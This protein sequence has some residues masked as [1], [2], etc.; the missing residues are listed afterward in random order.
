MARKQTKG[1]TTNL[2]KLVAWDI[3]QYI[4]L[5]NQ[6]GCLVCLTEAEKYV[7]SCALR[8]VPW[9]T[10]WTSDL[11]TQAPDIQ[12][13]G[14]VLYWKMYEDNCID[15]CQEILDCIETNEDIQRAIGQYSLTSAVTSTTQTNDGI[16]SSNVIGS[17]V[18][19]NNDQIFGMTIQLV[20]LMNTISLTLLDRFVASLNSAGNLGYLI[21]A[22]PVIGE[23]PLDDI[24]AFVQTVAVQIN[25]EY[26][27]SS[28]VQLLED[29][30]CKLFC[31]AKE[32]CS[33]TFEQISDYYNEQITAPVQFVDMESLVLDIILNGW[34]GD[35]AVYILHYFIVQTIIIGGE[36]TGIDANRIIKT[37]SSFYND[38]NSD[39]DTLCDPCSNEWCETLDLTVSSYGFVFDIEDGEPAGQWVDGV[40]LVAS[41]VNTGA[42]ATRIVAGYLPF[43][44]STVNSWSVD[45]SYTEGLTND[46]TA[47][48]VAGSLRLNGVGNVT[49]QVILSFNQVSGNPLPFGRSDFGNIQ[50]TSVRP[51]V[52]SS[53]GGFSG[54]VV[55]TEITVC[56]V[57]V[58]P[59]V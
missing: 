25:T 8:V 1:T 10:R 23:L 15:I 3:D 54:S 53:R 46:G 56:G 29:I 22:I 32:D 47:P 38:P 39:W 20:D 13:I 31:I 21:E 36:L 57:G 40:G 42:G 17:P 4:E 28:D 50:A 55:I 27:A 59:F 35:Q 18:G 14:E 52:K 49:A 9:S 24:L 48:S 5:D 37:V 11:G 2:S 41:D 19:C 16:A 26:Q 6:D 34:L 43:A 33:I 7:I 30:A 51:F 44:E 58:N 45:G 12:E